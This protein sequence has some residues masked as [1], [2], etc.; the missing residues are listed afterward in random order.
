METQTASALFWYIIIELHFPTGLGGNAIVSLSNLLGD[1]VKRSAKLSGRLGRLL[2]TLGEIRRSDA[3]LCG[4]ERGWRSRARVS[5]QNAEITGWDLEV[6]SVSAY[7]YQLQ[8]R[9]EELL[10]GEPKAIIERQRGLGMR[11][12][13]GVALQIF[14]RGKLISELKPQ[15]E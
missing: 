10:A 15:Q 14:D 13:N 4:G 3:E 1:K 5:A 2:F 11:I 8:L 12:A 7:A 6:T 9:L